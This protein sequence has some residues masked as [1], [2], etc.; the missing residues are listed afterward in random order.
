MDNRNDGTRR[1]VDNVRQARGTGEKEEG[2]TCG[3]QGMCIACDAGQEPPR[4]QAGGEGA[5]G[6]AGTDSE[7]SSA[8]TPGGSSGVAGKKPNTETKG[9]GVEGSSPGLQAR[10]RREVYFGGTKKSR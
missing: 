10:P 6:E 1:P 3:R 8:W 2:E 7:E 4:R 9:P 5:G